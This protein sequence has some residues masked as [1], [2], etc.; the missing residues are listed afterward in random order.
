ML[1]DLKTI[2]GESK[3]DNRKWLDYLFETQD[4]SYVQKLYKVPVRIKIRKKV[5]G[6]KSETEDDI[7]AVPSVTSLSLPRDRKS[8]T[9]SWF[10]TFDVKFELPQGEELMEFIRNQLLNDIRDIDGV[11]IITYGEPI[12]VYDAQDP[13]VGKEKQR[14]RVFGGDARRI[15]KREEPLQGDE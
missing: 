2:M 15:S 9:E 14:S 7:R 13:S 1:L 8:E 12:F 10:A 4:D 11:S 3:M 5:G 6:N